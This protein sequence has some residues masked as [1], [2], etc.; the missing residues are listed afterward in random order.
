MFIHD[1][2]QLCRFVFVRADPPSRSPYD[3]PR[4]ALPGTQS[5]VSAWNLHPHGSDLV[6]DLSTLEWQGQ[7][8]GGRAVSGSARSPLAETGQ[9]LQARARAADLYWHGRLL[10]S[11]A[12]GAHTNSQWPGRPHLLTTA[13]TPTAHACPDSAPP[14]FPTHTHIL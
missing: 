2:P 10:P 7:P 3:V 11:A 8:I 1:V 6:D 12:Q 14:V 4:P 9:Y 5:E 13:D